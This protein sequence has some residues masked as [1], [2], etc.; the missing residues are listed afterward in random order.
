MGFAPLSR[1]RGGP[2]LAT[3]GVSKLKTIQQF[4]RFNPLILAY[5]TLATREM[6]KG[7]RRPGTGERSLEK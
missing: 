4:I 1:E 3:D 2:E 6:E 7:I 5:T